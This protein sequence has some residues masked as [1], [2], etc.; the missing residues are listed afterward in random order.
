M[1]S[2]PASSRIRQSP[3]VLA[4][5]P[6]PRRAL[7]SVACSAGSTPTRPSWEPS[8]D[9]DPASTTPLVPYPE[10]FK[11]LGLK[12]DA[13]PGQA[14]VSKVCAARLANLEAACGLCGDDGFK[15]VYPSY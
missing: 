5:R 2:T 13:A 14:A 1:T 7:A 11:Y 3:P 6:L 4:A 9:P 10:L 15:A 8:C 12:T